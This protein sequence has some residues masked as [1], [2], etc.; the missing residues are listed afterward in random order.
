MSVPSTGPPALPFH[1]ANR[2]QAEV[3]AEDS[4][5]NMRAQPAALHPP[6]KFY[7]HYYAPREANDNSRLI[8]V[9]G[10]PL[11]ME[12][13]AAFCAQEVGEITLGV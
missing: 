1:S 10:I 6:H 13:C 7:Q 11:H 5:N 12:R 4:A 3:A 9:D 2:S 8:C